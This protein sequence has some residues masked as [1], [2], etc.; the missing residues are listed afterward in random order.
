MKKKSLHDPF[1]RETLWKVYKKRCFYCLDPLS[2]KN[3]HIDHV[4]PR[5]IDKKKV[6]DEYNLEPQFEFDSYYNLVPSC[7]SCNIKKSSNLFE[8]MRMLYLLDVI[9][10]NISKLENFEKSLR[11]KDDDAELSINIQ[12]AIK[13]DKVFEIL[14]IINENTLTTLE[15]GALIE[16]LKKIHPISMLSPKENR[17]IQEFIDEFN[18]ILLDFSKINTFCDKQGNRFIDSRAGIVIVNEFAG[19]VTYSL[20]A[21]TK[22]EKNIIREIDIKQWRT[23][24]NRGIFKYRTT[25]LSNQIL[26]QPI[27]TARSVIFEYY[28]KLL[29]TNILYKSK[30]NL[31]ATEFIIDFVDKY[32]NQ[33]G[34]NLKN[35]YSIEELLRSFQIYLPLWIDEALKRVDKTILNRVVK[36]NRYVRLSFIDFLVG[37]YREI[38]KNNVLERVHQEKTIFKISEYTSKLPI[39]TENLPFQIFTDFVFHLKNSQIKYINRIYKPPDYE[40][41]EFKNSN[42][43]FNAYSDK[44][45]VHNLKFVY[46]NTYPVYYD[47]INRIFQN[48]YNDFVP[49]SECS[50]LIIEIEKSDPQ[51]RLLDRA[52]PYSYHKYCLKGEDQEEFSLLFY[53]YPSDIISHELRTSRKWEEETLNHNGK[54]YKIKK[55]SEG[56]VGFIYEQVPLFKKVQE[57]LI[58]KFIQLLEEDYK[59][60]ISKISQIS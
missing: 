36:K 2:Y 25:D 4:I 30:N 40:R 34:L 27:D 42:R 47:V 55:I 35:Q 33:L 46:D 58:E 16:I 23:L 50:K 60:V 41:E 53:N 31:I 21:I 5:S 20:F 43:I 39:Y 32:A 6:I 38:I 24:A 12:K 29:S 14:K 7:T 3:L 15:H 11:K 59:R 19:S 1:V 17:K 48:M 9:E 22:N 8:K 52:E 56:L 44:A 49:F 13:E 37:S 54:I 51:I 28:A 26:S 18:R 57:L 10:R 45:I